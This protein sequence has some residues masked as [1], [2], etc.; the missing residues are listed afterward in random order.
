MMQYHHYNLKDIEEMVPWEREVYVSML[1]EYVKKE[2]ERL[3]RKM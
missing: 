3:K 2:N 1:I